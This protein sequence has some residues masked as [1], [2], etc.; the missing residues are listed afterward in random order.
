MNILYIKLLI[1]C[2]NVFIFFHNVFVRGYI[3]IIIARVSHICT[4]GKKNKKKISHN[5]IFA[6]EI[7]LREQCEMA[8]HKPF[9]ES[10]IS[11]LR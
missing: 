1:L 4:V 5:T 11:R 2:A 9:R 6:C 10:R 7:F 8:M 3:I